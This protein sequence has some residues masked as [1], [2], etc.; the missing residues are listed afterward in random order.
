MPAMKRWRMRAGSRSVTPAGFEASMRAL[1]G[2]EAAEA[3]VSVEIVAIGSSAAAAIRLR[4]RRKRR[5]EFAFPFRRECGAAAFRPTPC[6]WSP[7][8][9]PG[10]AA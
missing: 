9:V 8:E 5:I 1:F 3:A 4:Q 6:P 2:S 10:V 7:S